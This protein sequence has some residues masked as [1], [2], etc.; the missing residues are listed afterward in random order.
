MIRIR[1]A[2][3]IDIDIYEV[4]WL[5]FWSISIL[6]PCSSARP[7]SN[8]SSTLAL[9]LNCRTVIADRLGGFIRVGCI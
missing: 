4:G 9:K 3:E 2:S 5:L 7:G 8:E 1:V 6:T